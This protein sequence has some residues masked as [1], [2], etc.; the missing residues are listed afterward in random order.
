MAAGDVEHGVGADEA[1][2]AHMQVQ[3]ETGRAGHRLQATHVEVAEVSDLPGINGGAAGGVVG[4][5]GCA[6]KGALGVRLQARGV[7][8][9][10][11]ELSAETKIPSRNG[12]WQYD[13]CE[14]SQQRP[15]FG[16]GR[17]PGLL[18]CAANAKRK[19]GPEGPFFVRVDS[20]FSL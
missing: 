10:D 14:A 1:A 9:L 4:L 18:Y 5:F 15:L 3:R 11:D 6:Q 20:G 17:H 7:A 8:L 2:W 13:R 16:V 19:N 12:M